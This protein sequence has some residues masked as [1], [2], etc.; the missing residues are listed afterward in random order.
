MERD[1][2]LFCLIS[3]GVGVS[4]GGFGNVNSSQAQGSFFTL[5]IGPSLLRLKV[6]TIVKYNILV[7]GERSPVVKAPGCGPGDRGFKSHR[8]PQ[9][10][11]THIAHLTRAPVFGFSVNQLF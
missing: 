3:E 5:V 11:F 7:C 2:S 9:F 10:I 1:S 4:K 8:S 6:R